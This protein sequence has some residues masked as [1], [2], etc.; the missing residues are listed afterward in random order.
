MEHEQRH[1]KIRFRREEI[2]D[3]SSLPSAAEDPKPPRPR[4]S[5]RALKILAAVVGGLF[6][7]VLV[8]VAALYLVGLSGI[9]S[10]RIRLA[11]ETALREI[12]GVDVDVAMGPA[13]IT[14]DGM[15]FLAL[16]VNDVDLRS[17]SDGEK[18]ASAGSVRFG[19]R[20]LP[21]LT[22]D[23]K[24]SSARLSDASI[25]VSK[26]RTGAQA[27]WAKAF[28]DERGLIVPDL[29]TRAVFA[30]THRALDAVSS[31]ALRG[32][33]LEN[34]EVVL[35]PG[36]SVAAVK[37]LEARLAESDGD[38][39]IFSSQLE[40]G[41]RPVELGLAAERDDGTG[42]IVSVELTATTPAPD[43][44]GQAGNHVG[45]VDLVLNGSESSG[46]GSLNA[47]LKVSDWGVDLGPRGA[48]SGDLGFDGRL[49]AGTDRL[50]I[51]RLS[52][53]VGRSQFE[54]RGLVGPRPAT[55]QPDDEPGYRFNLASS[56]ASIAPDG[57]TEPALNAGVQLTGAYL[58]ERRQLSADQIVVKANGPGEVL[59]TASMVF[60]PGKVPGLSL[61]FSAYDMPVSQV[62][63]LWPWF[64][65]RPARNWVLGNV[66]GGRVTDGRLQVRFEPGRLGNGI[67]LSGDESFGSFRIEGT[68]FDTAGL[69]PPVRDA[70]GVVD[71]RGADIDIAL[72]SGTVYLP[73]GRTVA[74]SNG[75]L[76]IRKANVPP[77]IGALDIDVAGEAPAVAELASYEPINAMRRAGLVPDDFS[78]GEVTGNVKADIPLQKGID[79]ARLN[80]LVALDYKNLSMSKPFDGQVITDANGT[81]TV[82][83]TQA[84]IDA[85]AKLNGVPA[86]IAAIEPLGGSEAE[87]KRLITLTLDDKARELV[88]PGLAGLIEGPVKVE[89]DAGDRIKRIDADLTGAQVN[90]PWAGWSKGPGIGGNVSFL[91]E[92]IEGKSRLSDFKLSGET[93]G[94]AGNVL[95]ASG[96]LSEAQFSNV[97]LNRNDD[98]AVSVKQSGKGYVVDV[99]GKSLDARSV[100]KQFTSDSGTA[101]KSSDGSSVGSVTLSVNVD[102][103]TGFHDEKLGNVKLAYRG[104]GDRVDRLEVDAVSAS[105][106]KIQLRNGIADGGK[107]MRA[108]SSDAGAVL[109]FLD[110]Y[111]YMQGGKI[112]LALAGG[113]DGPMTGQVD[114][115]DFVLVNEPRLGSIVS[116]T[117]AGGDRSLNQAVRRDIDT[118]RVNFERLYSKVEKGTGY[119]RL[120]DGVLRG[121]LVGASFQGTLYDQKGNMDMTGTFMP[122]YGLNR[123]FGELPIV[124]VLL[125]NGRDGG[126]IGVTFKLT[127]DADAPTV[128]VNP[129]SV[130][131]PGIFRSIFE[132][133]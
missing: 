110:L 16:E 102:S 77:V 34:V 100:V 88:V 49:V 125:G 50:E 51:S 120:S 109:R 1:E 96:S 35:P 103:V 59:G 89:V 36:G 116:T 6:A 53:S 63:Q 45:A 131:A 66:F 108:N 61:A 92:D 127:G 31:K 74:A 99:K 124:G 121:Q 57:S 44:A 76:A 41:S 80:W 98:V 126:L 86:Q 10:E 9:G 133:R 19:V 62:K 132:F 40:I 69:I 56:R 79:P 25:I 128:Q 64:S 81:I 48:V 15:R 37:I 32:I 54:F 38:S 75:N 58:P 3:L 87:R 93:F 30:A 94:I 14:L 130:I 122:A 72:S 90:I 82:E 5:G 70:T 55:G 107:T 8:A 97:K 26:L 46:Q 111:E 84:V 113:V 20:L 22:G 28:R 73:S 33:T 71:Y 39:L 24:V 7:L 43:E 115:R 21:L 60:V 13:Y 123:I 67:P 129:L 29:V 12:A 18:I 65:A 23:V 4:S 52:A 47:S 42:R 91:L 11:A 95:L 101:T 112:D 68:R 104:R 85:K 117:P 106:G 119:L 2:A 27:D 114:A 78:G 118:S 17:Q 105:G 83:K